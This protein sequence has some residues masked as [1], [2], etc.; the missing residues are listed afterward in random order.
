MKANWTP[1]QG[2]TEWPRIGLWGGLLCENATQGICAV[3]LRELL[4][5][6]ILE[7]EA[8]VVGHTHDESLL[9]VPIAEVERW[10]RELSEAMTTASPWGDGL[11][12]AVDIWTGP[13]Y[14]K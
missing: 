12:L 10:T 7:R 14:R 13:R 8:P 1:K 5:D 3:L 4:A 6:L 2:E 11:P 9:E